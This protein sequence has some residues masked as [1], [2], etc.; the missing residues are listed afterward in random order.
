M[1][2]AI[3]TMTVSLFAG[4]HELP[5]N[6]GPLYT[7]WDFKTQLGEK[8]PLVASALETLFDGID[9]NV[10][11]TGLTPA[12]SEFLSLAFAAG[13]A[14]LGQFRTVGKLTLL[15]FDRDTN[16]YWSQRIW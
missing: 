9:V 10:Y 13:V 16:G 1:T 4:R 3:K 6:E 12:L 2:N 8:S 15:H 14:T 7:G 11:V 5:D